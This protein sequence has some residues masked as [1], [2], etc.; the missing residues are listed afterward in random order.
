MLCRGILSSVIG[1]ER[2]CETDGLQCLGMFVGIY[3]H[4]ILRDEATCNCTF[5]PSYCIWYIEIG[6]FWKVDSGQKLR[7]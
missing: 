3:E 7:Q 6:R 1:R 2:E 5:Y 4:Q